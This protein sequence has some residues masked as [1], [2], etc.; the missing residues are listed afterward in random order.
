M[1]SKQP[2]SLQ[3]GPASLVKHLQAGEGVWNDMV[4]TFEKNKWKGISDNCIVQIII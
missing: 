4:S 2:K 3:K 1:L